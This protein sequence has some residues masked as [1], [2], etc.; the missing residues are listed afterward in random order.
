M[1]NELINEISKDIQKHEQRSRLRTTEEQSRFDCAVK[2]L[3]TDVWRACYSIPIRECSINL[4]SGYYSE[5]PRY[6][7]PQLAYRQIKAVYDALIAMRQIEITREGYYDK[8]RMEG[9]LTCFVARDELLERLQNLEGHP[10]I[11]LQPNLNM[12]SILLRNTI[13]VRRQ[14]VDYEETAQT[15][16]YRTNLQKINTCFSKH[17]ADLKIKDT[18][19]SKLEDRLHN[20]EDKYPIDLSSRTLSRIFSSGSFKEGGRFYRGWW[21]NAPSE[22]RKYITLDGKKTAEYDFSQLNPH[23]IY[24]AYNKEMGSEDAYDRVLDGEHRDIVKQAFNAMIQENGPLNQ[25]PRDINLDGLEMDWKDLRQRILDAHKPIQYLFFDGLGNKLQFE[26]SCIAES[27]MLHF[28]K[29]D[30]PVLPVHDSF[31]MHHGYGGELEEAMRRGFHE[32]FN[33]DIPVKEEILEALPSIPIEE[34]PDN[35]SV[36][37]I[38]KGEVEYSQWQDRDRMWWERAK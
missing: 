22:Y 18:E 27:V 23:M 20:H 6:R 36:D 38:L 34:Q 15:E 32:R 5:N 35:L 10:A 4:R 31:I 37:E 19:I 28:Q 1:F 16:K 17:W 8:V 7:D 33:S 3:L 30:A 29:M 9:S 12:E 11:S 25:K 24:F 14:L 13:D 2:Y 26:D 21:Q